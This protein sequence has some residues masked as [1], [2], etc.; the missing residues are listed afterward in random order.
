MKDDDEWEVCTLWHNRKHEVKL[1]I[2]KD[3]KIRHTYCVFCD[4]SVAFE[5]K[6]LNSEGF[7]TYS[8]LDIGKP[9]DSKNWGEDSQYENGN[10]MCKCINC[11]EVF[12]GHK[13]RMIC[14][15]CANERLKPSHVKKF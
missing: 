13:R 10:Y 3:S 5:R 8:M 9:E 4:R 15:V 14:K 12:Q 1:S 2:R 11:G 7:D 6:P